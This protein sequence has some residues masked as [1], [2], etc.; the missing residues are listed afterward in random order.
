MFIRRHRVIGVSAV[1][2][3][4]SFTVGDLA[5][6]I[7]AYPICLADSQNERQLPDS[8]PNGETEN[9]TSGSTPIHVDDCFCCSHCVEASVEFS[10][11]T[12]AF[13]QPIFATEGLRDL[14][15]LAHNVS[16]PPKI[17]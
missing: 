9:G 2:F 17:S 12:I 6:D 14:P 1:F 3:L 4:L 11:V 7:L 10:L 5:G 8:P 15:L 16:H 13:V